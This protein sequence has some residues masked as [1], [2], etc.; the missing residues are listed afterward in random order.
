MAIIKALNII[1]S[2]LHD[3]RGVDDQVCFLN[4]RRSC[5]YRHLILF[6]THRTNHARGMCDAEVNT[7][8]DRNSY[9]T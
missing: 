2:N 8:R 7:F 5:Q 9:D 6:S 1:C 4:T 3:N